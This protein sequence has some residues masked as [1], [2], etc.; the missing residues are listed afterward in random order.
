MAQG[1]SADDKA[2][3]TSNLRFTVPRHDRGM[4]R[5]TLLQIVATA[6]PLLGASNAARAAEQDET[7]QDDR[8]TRAVPVRLRWPEGDAACGLVIHSHGLVGSRSGADAWGQAWQ[9]AGFAVLHLQHAGS[10]TEVLRGGMRAMRTAASAEQ[11]LARVAD[12]HFAV[13][14]ITR[15]VRRGGG[16]WSRVHTDALGFSGHSFGA[17]TV[18]AVAGQRFAVPTHGIGE[19]RLKAF[20]AFSPSLGQAPAPADAFAGVTRPFLAVTGSLDSDSLGRGLSGADR[21]R[22][23]DALP[24]GQ[25]ALLWL[26]GADHMTFAGNGTQ[27]LR[28]RFGPLK[29]EALAADRETQHHASIAAITTLWWRA[30][31]LGDVAANAALRAPAG[32]GA[33]DR[34]RQD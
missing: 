19:P 6:G 23:Y 8:R 34:W 11:L 9:R 27:P 25:R 10:D 33:G 20:I 14:E 7:W 5:R 22:V 12:V 24:S 15:R 26:D 16:G 28:A 29:R 13:D 32:L 17:V 2:T 30:K 31:L 21:A 1:R 3:S 18:Q 4:K